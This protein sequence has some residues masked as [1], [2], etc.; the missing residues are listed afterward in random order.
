M[1]AYFSRNST[2]KT[3]RNR[4]EHA[5]LA[6]E[7]L[8]D[9]VLLAAE[10][11][12]H[13]SP[14]NPSGDVQELLWNINNARAGTTA[15][16]Q[17]IVDSTDVDTV[18]GIANNA[19][20]TA[21]FQA[22]L[23]ARED[24]AGPLPP[25]AFDARLAEIALSHSND[26]ASLTDLSVLNTS[27]QSTYDGVGDNGTTG[28]SVLDTA[29]SVEHAHNRT[30]VDWNN[31][32]SRDEVLSADYDVTGLAY[33]RETD[34]SNA[35]GPFVAVQTYVDIDNEFL[36]ENVDPAIYA[37]SYFVGTV[38]RD[39]NNNGRYDFDE[40]IE[41]VSVTPDVG[42]WFAVTN[43]GGGYSFPITGNPT[44][45]SFANANAAIPPQSVAIT[46][47]NLLVDVELNAMEAQ[48]DLT[49]SVTFDTATAD[50]GSEVDLTYTV[51]N[52]GDA[53]ADAFD[54][55]IYFSND[56]EFGPDD[57][58]NLV[59][60]STVNTLDVAGQTEDTT[61]I[62]LPASGD[63][64]WSNGDTVYAFIFVD[65][66]GAISESNENNN[67]V[68]STNTV[69]ATNTGSALA[70]LQAGSVSADVGAAVAGSTI[71]VSY[72]VSNGGNAGAGP[73]VLDL[74]LSDDDRS[75]PTD[76]LLARINLPS[77][78][79]GATAE[80]TVQVTLPASGNAIYVGD[81]NYKILALLDATRVVNE[82][83]AGELDNDLVS[84]N[85]LITGTGFQ[86]PELSA[87]A[88]DVAAGTGSINAGGVVPVDFTINNTGV[89]N[90]DANEAGFWLSADPIFQPDEDFA[91]D[92]TVSV[93]A[94]S[95][96]SSFTTSTSLRTPGPGHPFW[97]TN[98]DG[99]YYVIMFIDIEGDVT[100]SNEANNQVVSASQVNIV[101]TDVQPGSLN[102]D[103]D[104]SGTLDLTDVYDVF[105][106]LLGSPD[107]DEAV[108][109]HLTT[110]NALSTMLDADRNGVSNG[111]D[112]ALLYRTA[113]GISEIVGSL[114]VP[115]G[116]TNDSVTNFL[117]Q[118]NIPA[119]GPLPGGADA[120]FSDDDDDLFE[121]LLG[122]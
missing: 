29:N 13:S 14:I 4:R 82:G 120:L 111:V 33:V 89:A 91:I 122:V 36:D 24:N 6:T 60:T 112:A 61:T 70:N 12:H 117:A 118:F 43:A 106:H 78:G 114:S 108:E 26:L 66:A 67:I 99:D 21:A 38:W 57:L 110:N 86:L 40:G 83:T 22:D 28:A 103:V 95:A 47:E 96:G 42:D 49:G 100:E 2:P 58:D 25:L 90:A 18:A 20:D 1:F 54:V 104:E 11:T 65:D 45:L 32:G 109:E 113:F 115:A 79:A 50:A 10:W 15:E 69:A 5:P 8:E 121:N 88:F 101:N 68:L 80:G 75:E 56:A 31:L 84:P 64:F 41:G 77:I 63:D 87:S 19:V 74:V 81:T 9:R 93:P 85:L 116:V 44:T 92:P 97:D 55:K 46:G 53:A 52:I 71:N 51:Q 94:I 3:R 35:V 107:L 27:I 34:P 119:G 37:E 62:N 73:S 76:E 23:T 102:F 59:S 39:L 30:I 17:R 98:G 7:A 72:V 105:S 48:A 16:A